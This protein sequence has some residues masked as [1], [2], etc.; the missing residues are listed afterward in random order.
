MEHNVLNY[1]KYMLYKMNKKGHLAAIQKGHYR[2][3]V[4]REAFKVQIIF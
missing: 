1:D 3:K 2:I 4:E